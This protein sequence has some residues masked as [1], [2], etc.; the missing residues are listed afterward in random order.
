MF[1]P[2]LDVEENLTID[3]LKEYIKK[4]KNFKINITKFIGY[5]SNLDIADEYFFSLFL[6]ENLYPFCESISYREDSRNITFEICPNQI[7]LN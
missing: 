4:H 3:L 2:S 6:G 7:K 5:N 1:I